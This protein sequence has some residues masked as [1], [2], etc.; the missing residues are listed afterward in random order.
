LKHF[1]EFVGLSIPGHLEEMPTVDTV[2]C[3]MRRFTSGWLQETSENIPEQFRRSLTHISVILCDY[4]L[5]FPITV[6]SILTG[7]SILK[8]RLR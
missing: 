4:L 1:A 6:I 8:D 3:Y 2:R 7:E 5:R